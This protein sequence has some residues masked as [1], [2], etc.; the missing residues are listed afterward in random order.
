MN[1]FDVV[2]LVAL[3]VLAAITI[4]FAVSRHAQTGGA[5][6]VSNTYLLIPITLFFVLLYVA[7][8]R[9]PSLI[10]REGIGSAII[11]AAPLILAT[12]ALTP[13]ALAGRGGV[14]LSV[15]PLIGFINVTLIQWLSANGVESATVFFLYALG[16]AVLYQIAFGLI[17]IYVRVQPIIVALSGF[18][19]LS[20]LNLV[21]L[22]RP[23]GVAP[24]W[25]MPWGSGDSILSPVLAILVL[26][27]IGWYLLDRSAFFGHLRMMGSDERAAY[28][29]GVKIN[30][31]RLGAHIVAGLFSGLAAITF[32]ALI[33][34]GDPTQGSTYTLMAVTG[35]VLGG[36]SL[37]G[38]RGGIM[39][40]LLGAINI[41]L[42]TYVLAT[43]SF[44]KVQSFVT[45][46]AYGLVL[47]VSLLLTL[48]IPRLQAW[49]R[50]SPLLYFIVLAV[51]ATGITLHSQYDYYPEAEESVEAAPAAPAQ[52]EGVFLF[53]DGAL[54]EG[55]R[56][57]ADSLAR[58]ITYA[59]IVAITVIFM[60]RVTIL[61]AQRRNMTPL[62][63]FV[64][65]SL[66]AL[67]IYLQ[68]R[69]PADGRAALDDATAIVV[70]EASP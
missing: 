12:Y 59:T 47:V 27:T 43:F 5:S 55:E 16:A 37:A 60:L 30:A 10:T 17:V 24:M 18:L 65:L 6:T 67:A 52:P 64:V 8:L 54:F 31:V 41:Y 50:V 51:V 42:I 9:S 57:T 46:L 45:D 29:S 20:G 13:I 14:D 2:V 53:E 36:T 61:Q 15:G 11:V 34:S 21:I 33:S 56:D 28:T 4:L 26:A 63:V 1:A 7:V 32:T 3:G 39:G 35:L 48:L 70:T 38:G 19:A 62:V 69:A 68:T 22:P 44:G 25:L 23:G 58:Q 49:L 66:V 40:S